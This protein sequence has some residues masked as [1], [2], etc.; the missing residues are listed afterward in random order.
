MIIEVKVRLL[1]DDGKTELD[2]AE[3]YVR[4]QPRVAREMPWEKMIHSALQ[5]VL[6]RQLQRSQGQ[7]VTA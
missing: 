7:G 1:Q 4:T 2:T 3:L 5:E 6:E